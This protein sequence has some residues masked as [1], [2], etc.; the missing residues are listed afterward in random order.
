MVR[1]V[2]FMQYW[3]FLGLRVFKKCLGCSDWGCFFI[4]GNRIKHTFVYKD[5]KGRI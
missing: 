1:N 3:L 2:V 4:K 5:Q